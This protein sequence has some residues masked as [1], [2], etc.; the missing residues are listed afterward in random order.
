MFT[1]LFQ[2]FQAPTESPLEGFSHLMRHLT[3]FCAR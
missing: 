2:F 1:A 3:Q